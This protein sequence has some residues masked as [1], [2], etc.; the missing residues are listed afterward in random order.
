MAGVPVT[1]NKYLSNGNSRH[2]IPVVKG[3]LEI[4]KLFT[5]VGDVTVAVKQSYF[6][7]TPARLLWYLVIRYTETGGL[8]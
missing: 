2:I 8:F 6:L 1:L 3:A 5:L 7:G 4:F